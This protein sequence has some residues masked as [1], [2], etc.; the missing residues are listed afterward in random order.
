MIETGRLILRRWEERDAPAFHAMGQDPRVMEY[1]GPPMGRADVDAAMAR[2]NGFADS[3]GCCFWAMERREDGAFLGFCGIKPGASDTPIEGRSEIGWRLAAQY[4]G[5]GFAREAAE[6]SLAHG[7]NALG[8]DSVWAITTV[9][10]SRSWGLMERLGM[11]R[12]PD[13]DFDHRLPGLEARLR[14]HIT[15]SIGRP[16]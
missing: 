3:H 14:P 2:Q 4:W 6:A 11:R 8:L 12:H 7:W 10:N 1:L 16:A 5:Q 13:L 15:Y 9:G